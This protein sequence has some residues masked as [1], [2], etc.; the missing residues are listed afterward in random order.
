MKVILEGLLNSALQSLIEQ[1][2]LSDSAAPQI[3]HCKNKEHGDFASN[4]ALV[5]A[6]KA[7]VSPRELATLIIKNLPSHKKLIKTEIAGPGFINFFVHLNKSEIIETIL[8]E[9]DNFGSSQL[10]ANA[11]VLIEYVSANPTGPLHVG[12]GRG[13]AFGSALAMLLR[14]AGFTVDTE[15][16]VNDAGRQMDI[17]ALSV[18]LRYLE[19]SGETITF[20]PNAY[21]GDYIKTIAETLQK[22]HG[23]NLV[24]PASFFFD[25]T[26]HL[27]DEIL[28]DTLIAKLKEN[29]TSYL[30]AHQAAL[31]EIL[32][33]IKNDLADFGVTFTHWFSEKQ[34]FS[35]GAIEDAIKILEE[36]KLTYQKDHAIWFKATDFGDEKDRVLKRGNGQTTY[37]T[38]DVAYHHLKYERGYTHVIDIFGADHHGYVPRVIASLTALGHNPNQLIVK[39]VQFAVLYRGQEKVQMSTRSGEFVTLRTLREEVGTDAARFFYIYRKPEQHMDFDLELAKSQTADN[40][41]YYIQYAHAR[42]CRMVEKCEESH[43]IDFS[44]YQEHLSLLTLDSEEALLDKLGT[45]QEMIEKAASLYEPHHIAHYLRDLAGLFHSYYNSCKVI[46]DDK[47]LMVARLAL[48]LAVKQV[49]ANGLKLLGVNAPQSM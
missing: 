42:I 15:Y 7:G 23:A 33:D 24:Q 41:V 16:Y 38:S 18:Y 40:P 45:Y 48:S 20:P 46:Q 14:Q 35:S 8:E 11:K 32:L 28:I 44:N 19:I 22:D 49:I 3:D 29:Q 31:D 30:A 25:G 6:K 12:H 1:N 47:N 27:E 39:L 43:E 13:A 10:G 34:L 5:L 4:I 9:K 37:F 36:K 26:C 2:I 17:L 21:R